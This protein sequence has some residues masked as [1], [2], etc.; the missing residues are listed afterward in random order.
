MK[1]ETIIAVVF[2]ILLGGGLAVV[3]FF[4]NKQIQL[5]K[6]KAIA[7]NKKLNIYQKSTSI[8]LQSLEILEPKD[9]TIV[10]KNKVIISGKAPK[11][12]LLVVQ[13]PVK[14]IILELKK[15]RFTIDFPLTLGENFIRI[16]VYPKDKK[17]RIQEKELK[18]YYLKDQ[19]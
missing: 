5:E 18:V 1:K 14:D 3:I 6:S 7:V 4:K 10:D 16:V 15:D 9:S 17:L 2:G 19:L 13:S 8:N 12:S 11:D